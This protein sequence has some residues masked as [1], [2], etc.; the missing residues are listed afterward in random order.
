MTA[1][2]AQFEALKNDVEAILASKGI[3][4]APHAVGEKE[5][6]VFREPPAYV[7]VPKDLKDGE[8]PTTTPAVDEVREIA[9]YREGVEV[10]IWGVS[11]KQVSAMRNNVIAALQESALANWRIEGGAWL[12]PGKAFNQLGELFRLDI[13]VSEPAIDGYVDLELLEEPEADGIVPT[14]I[15][16]RLGLVETVNDEDEYPLTTTTADTG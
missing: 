4:T 15:E 6:K 16:G 9:T 7:W 2:Q 1:W 8:E 12:N 5:L 13:T 10:W 14:D 11:F 3:S